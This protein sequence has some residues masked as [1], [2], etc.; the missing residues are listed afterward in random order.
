MSE[1]LITELKI[2]KSVEILPERNL[3]IEDLE[4]AAKTLD[5]V[6]NVIT[7]PENPG[8]KPGVDPFW[9]TKIVSMQTDAI[10]VPH[11]TSRDKNRIYI[12]SQ[13]I[14]AIKNDIR[15]FFVIGGDPIDPKF[16]SIEVREMN[17]NSIIREIRRI[18]REEYEERVQINIGSGYNPYRTEE[19]VISSLK[20]EAGADFFMTQ[21]LYSR[22][23]L[24]ERII[25]ENNLKIIPGFIPITRKGTINFLRKIGVNMTKAEIYKLIESDDV[26]G[27]SRRMFID[28]YDEIRKHVMGIHIMPMGNYALARDILESV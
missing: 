21:P 5:G 9:T 24:T 19:N 4:K 1:R 14:S 26:A 8:G 20:I 10:A 27:T 23:Y 6:A 12:I 17:T 22:G 25:L 28:A 11:I 7:A 2:V 3:G 13:I 18:Q 16:S 15:N